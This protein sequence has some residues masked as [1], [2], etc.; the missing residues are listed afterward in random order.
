MKPENL[1]E[2]DRLLEEYRDIFCKNK[3]DIGF[4][5]FQ[6]H[7]IELVEGAEPHKEAFRRLNPEKR[8]SADQQVED[9]L[10]LGMISPSDSPF[11][12]GV[13]MVKKTDGSY[14]MCIDFRNLNSVTKK[15]AFPLPRID[16]TLDR[17]GDAK[18]FSTL[19]MGSGFWQVPL[20]ER[21]KERTAFVTHRGQFQWNRMPFG[22]C[23]ANRHVPEADDESASKRGTE[24][25]QHCPVLRRRYPDSH[26]DAGTTLATTTSPSSRPAEQSNLKLKAAKCKLFDTEIKFLGRLVT[27]GGIKPDPDS[28]KTIQDYKP[29]VSKKQVASF[30]GV[31]GYY[32]EFVEDYADLIAPL[33]DLKKGDV[34]FTWGPAQKESFE[35]TK[36]AL[37]NT[38]MLAMPN[39]DGMFVLDTKATKSSISGVLRQWQTNEETG[40]A[41]LRVISHGSRSLTGAQTRYAQAKLD[42]FAALKM[43]EKF[44]P[45]LTNKKFTLRASDAAFLWLR[46]RWRKR[47]PGGALD[48][49]PGELQVQ[50]RAPERNESRSN[51]CTRK[52]LWSAPQGVLQ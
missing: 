39:Q 12:S 37:V 50:P 13:V 47:R 8:A 18:Y 34:D 10:K 26:S 43:I 1:T 16:E 52:S 14:R 30:L 4:T 22:L 29:P 36:N 9:L 7:A 17:L 44:A 48:L 2:L 5:T 42:M 33:Q 28:I 35:R 27:G 11:A 31:T 19:D 32:R 20:V 45:H 24:V 25:W 38:P 51:L 23:N 49:P 46:D 41:T 15:D 3:T 21:A 40:E 6:E